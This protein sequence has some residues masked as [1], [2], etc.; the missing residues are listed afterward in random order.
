M[1][2][3]LEEVRLRVVLTVV[4]LATGLA[5]LVVFMLDTLVFDRLRRMSELFERIPERMARG[6]YRIE[7]DLVPP[8]DDELGRFERL[9]H[10][11]VEVIGGALREIGHAR[12]PQ[13]RDRS[14]RR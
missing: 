5:A 11:A 12:G 14:A 2:A 8:P 10:R 7:T 1:R 6:D 4:L 9:F 13:D 3:G